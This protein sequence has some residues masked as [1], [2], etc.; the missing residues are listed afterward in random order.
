MDDDKTVLDEAAEQVIELGN[1][2]AA[3]AELASQARGVT[4]SEY[5]LKRVEVLGDVAQRF[6]QVVANQEALA[7]ALTNRQLAADALRTVQERVTAGKGSALEESKAQVALA[8]G[9]LLVEGAQHELNAARK[10][11][12]ASWRSRRIHSA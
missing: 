4:K 10:K 7:L 9:E 2:R 8:R 3:R 11:F 5:E 6:I 1:K 12:A